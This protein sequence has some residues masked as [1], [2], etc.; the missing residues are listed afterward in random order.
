MSREESAGVTLFSRREKVNVWSQINIIIS[1]L[2]V[3][4][5][6]NIF[7]EKK[8]FSSSDDEEDMTQNNI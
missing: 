5:F 4:V 6:G 1:R 7:V 3:C 8:V 2:V